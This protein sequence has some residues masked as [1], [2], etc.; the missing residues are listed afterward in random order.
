MSELFRVGDFD[1]RDFATSIT[2]NQYTS[3][4]W[5]V[6]EL[7]KQNS[8]FGKNPRVMIL[9]AWYGSFLIPLLRDQ[10]NPK[11]IIVNDINPDVLECARILHDD[12]ICSY[13]C[14]DV[15]QSLDYIKK[16]KV[17]VLIN[18]SCE[19]MFDMKNVITGSPNTV[20]ALQSCDN[21]NDPGHINTAATTDQ[22]IEQTGLTDVLFRGRLSLSNKT[23]FMVIG[24][25]NRIINTG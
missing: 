2:S 5:L 25:K 8:V 21:K 24:T 13:E 23:R 18:T 11:S 16:V 4:Q 17:D 20:Y 10:I 12:D 14:F 3:K 22:F 19:H 1:S 9:G 7:A 15:E 6:K